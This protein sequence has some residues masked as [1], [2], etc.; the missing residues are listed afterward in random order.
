MHPEGGR[1]QG[2]RNRD[3]DESTYRLCS[4]SI[5]F[6]SRRTVPSRYELSE[7]QW[8]RMRD[9]FRTQGTRR[10]YGGRQPPVRQWG[11]MGIAFRRAGATFRSAMASTKARIS[12]LCAGLKFLV[13]PSPR[14]T[15]LAP[16]AGERLRLSFAADASAQS[17]CAEFHMPPECRRPATRSTPQS[18]KSNSTNPP[19]L[20][21]LFNSFMVR[22]PLNNMGGVL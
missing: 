2:D 8:E 15:S 10:P 18:T 22:T 20:L 13:V 9:F 7:G 3:S 5:C 17:R 1:V 19:L 12:G 16:V 6:C 21:P 4:G 14:F 11:V